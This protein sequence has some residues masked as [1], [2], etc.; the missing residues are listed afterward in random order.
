M[1]LRISWATHSLTA[2]LSYK[3]T[4]KMNPLKHN[5]YIFMLY[6]NMLYY[7]ILYTVLLQRAAKWYNSVTD[8]LELEESLGMEEE[9]TLF[10]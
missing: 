7:C 2:N 5:V 9:D 8:S 3:E 10:V 6:G 1:S 4:S